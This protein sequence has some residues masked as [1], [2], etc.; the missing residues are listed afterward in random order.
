[1]VKN[2]ILYFKGRGISK[3]NEKLVSKY[4]AKKTGRYFTFLS[5]KY[6]NYEKEL[7]KQAIKQLLKG[8]K[9]YEGNVWVS[10]IFYFKNRVHADICNLPKSI[11]DS[12]TGVLWKDDRQCWLRQVRP[13]YSKDDDEGFTI[14][15]EEVKE[16]D[17]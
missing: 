10:L 15:V 12:M 6:R 14:T 8:F 16:C 2:I 9:P 7:K 3:D 1:M 11:V 17:K 13:F 4:P 5:Q